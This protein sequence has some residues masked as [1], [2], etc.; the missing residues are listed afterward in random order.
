MSGT[1]TFET[2]LYTVDSGI[3]TLT[4]N[5]PDRH[6][7]F[8]ALMAIELRK[9]W[10]EIKTDPAVV[11]AIVTGAGER[12]FCSGMDVADVASGDA[13]N[14]SGSAEQAD[15]R[16]LTPIQ[17]QCWKP[18]IAAV[19]GMVV[20]GGLH[21]VVDADLVVCAEHAT[22]LDTHV[23]VGLVAGLE[24][25]GLARKIPLEAVLRLS[26]LGGSERMSAAEALRVGL[27]GEVLPADEVLPRART[28]AEMIS[29]HSPTALAITKQRIWE[30]LDEGL[31]TALDRTW[32]AIQEHREH[33]DLIEGARAY[34]EKRKPNWKPYTG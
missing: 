3:A 4:L 26:L 24:P 20:G 1:V 13:R 16:K 31:D 30:S 33:P 10:Q 23:K 6:N 21:F 12:A 32:A 9:V 18:V 25:V 2:L 14:A 11:C 28:L 34:V 15:W 5:R 19:N 29:Q 17:N 8:N 7:A 27:V 22:F